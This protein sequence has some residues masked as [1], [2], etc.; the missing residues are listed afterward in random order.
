MTLLEVMCMGY[1]KVNWYAGIK[2]AGRMER[3][4]HSS[5]SLTHGMLLCGLVL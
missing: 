1:T 2:G 3:E 5:W 4:M